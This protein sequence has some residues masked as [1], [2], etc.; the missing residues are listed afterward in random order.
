MKTL[1]ELTTAQIEA[2]FFFAYAGDDCGIY[3]ALLNDQ[4]ACTKYEAILLVIKDLSP[5]IGSLLSAI[6]K[7]SSDLEKIQVYEDRCNDQ[8][9]YEASH[10]WIWSLKDYISL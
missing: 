8:Y 2:G 7:V 9:S 3:A 4:V 10:T 1:T 6:Y 5:W